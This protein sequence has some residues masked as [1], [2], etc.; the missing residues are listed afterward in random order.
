M[1]GKIF[2][3]EPVFWI[4]AIQIVLMLLLTIDK[5]AAQLSLTEAKVG[6]IAVA[7]NLLAAI[8]Q[9][10]VVKH[11]VLAALVELLKGAAALFFVFGVTLDPETMAQLIA[12]VSFIGSAYLRDRTAPLVQPEFNNAITA[13]TLTQ[14]DTTRAA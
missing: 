4:G 11:G 12:L 1:S 7:L 8:Y 13:P 2:G 10:W 5:V 9:A 6:A 3:K 14:A